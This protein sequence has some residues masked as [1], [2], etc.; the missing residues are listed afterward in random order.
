MKNLYILLFFCVNTALFAQQ[1][2][3]DWAYIPVGAAQTYHTIY[4]AATDASGNIVELG[5][6]MGRAD[7]NP[8]P[9]DTVL[10]PASSFNF[11]L[12]KTSNSG[13]LLWIKY[14]GYNGITSFFEF[15]G[16]KINTN[17]EIVVAGNYYG[18]IDFDLS[19]TGVD[20][21]R[22]HE[23][24]YPDFFVAKYDA[25]G[26][27]QW[28][29]SFGDAGSPD[30]KSQAIALLPNNNIVVAINPTGS[31][32]TDLDPSAAIH[33]TIGSNGNL[34]CYSPQGQ[35]VWNAHTGTLYSQ[36]V[37]N[38]S[39]ECDDWGNA[40]LMTVAYYKLTVSK[41][42]LLGVNLWDK[43]IG[44][45]PSG[46][47]VNPQSILVEKATGSFYV[48]GTFGGTVDFD[49][50]AG[51]TNRSASSGNYQDG[52]IAKY[53]TDMNLLWVNTYTGKIN[54]GSDALDF[55]NGEI[56]AVG[57]FTSTVDFGN[58]T[59][60]NT[61]SSLSPFY[62]RMNSAGVTQTGFSLQG[63]GRFGTINTN[64][65]H[66]SVLTGYL[67]STTDVDPS[68]ANLT[69]TATA[70]NAFTGVYQ[71]PIPVSTTT[72][73]AKNNISVSPNPMHESLNLHV[74]ESLINTDY[75][76]Y[77]TLGSFI[78]KG[79]I[80]AE[81]TNIRTDNIAAGVYFLHIG[82]NAVLKLVKE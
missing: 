47:R 52:F 9:A 6:M 36:T 37:P 62:I 3:C 42:T 53:D 66:K 60:L 81:T 24:T 1:P 77:N 34:V 12:S 69:L 56:V 58:G 14:F 54:F 21:L 74:A 41:F 5:K 25:A 2:S 7:M 64:I 45:F 8:A 51:V 33:G 70:T 38:N 59:I 72:E 80:K 71:F 65:N 17:N 46:G 35:Y 79:K 26:G 19:A 61:A 18:L 20:T 78:L 40:Y 67:V 75:A 55:D 73:I 49:P 63:V 23:R 48:A 22:S 82:E 32:A 15:T 68:P 43:T 28:A 31:G 30:I 16:L 50:N 57:D 44:D 27:Y 11:Y 10:S 29:K 76:L 39:V 4:Y 13:N